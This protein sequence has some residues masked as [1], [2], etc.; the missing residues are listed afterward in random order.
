[1]EVCLIANV[2]Q[3]DLQLDGRP[4]DASRLRS[5]GER[6]GGE[7]SVL[8]DRLSAPIVEAALAHIRSVAEKPKVN[9]FLVATDQDDER[10]REGDTA[11]C[12]AVIERLLRERRLASEVV[13]LQTKSPP[14]RYDRMLAYYESK[15]LS[16]KKLKGDRFYLLLAGGTPAANTALL[17]AGIWRFGEN[18]HVLNVGEDTITAR[19]MDVGRRIVSSYRDERVN[20]LLG[21]YDFAGAGLLI[22][23]VH[24]RQVADA[25]AKRLN[26]EFG[27][28][29]KILGET[30]SE[31]G[32]RAPRELDALYEEGQQLAA[33]KQGIVLREV[34]WNA[35]VKWRLE[36]YADFLG[37]AWRMKEAALQEAVGQVCGLDLTNKDKSREPFESWVRTCPGLVQYLEMKKVTG[38]IEQSA[39]LL[40]LILDWL[41]SENGDDFSQPLRKCRDAN[42]ELDPLRQLR[43]DCV[44]A[45]GFEGLSKEVILNKLGGIDEEALFDALATLLVVWTMSPGANPYDQFAKLIQKLA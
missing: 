24:A 23:D 18:A 38:P 11:T 42:N 41:A 43:N 7:Y 2:G 13:V 36:E 20:E 27:P 9:V 32:G 39:W 29:V 14:N 28:S 37:R 1:M 6:L 34:Y 44:L 10:Y 16:H 22:E 19:P 31:I 3:R 15:A 26:F 4:L 45:H 17:L 8:Q 33:G 5:E 12:A 21:R 25:A 40:G 35:V 30:L